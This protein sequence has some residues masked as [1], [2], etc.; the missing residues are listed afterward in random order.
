MFEDGPDFQSVRP[1]TFNLAVI[2]E[3]PLCSDQSQVA[4]RYAVD[5][6]CLFIVRCMLII[7]QASVT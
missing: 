7:K 3:R 1:Q 4:C 5:E 2:E 6:L